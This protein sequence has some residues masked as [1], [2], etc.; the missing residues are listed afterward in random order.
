[1]IETLLGSFVEAVELRAG[2]DA[3]DP[4]LREE[5]AALGEVPAGRD[6]TYTA[7]RHCARRALARLG[8]APGPVLIGDDRAPVWPDGVVGSITHCQGYAAAAVARAAEVAA[9]GID[10][11]PHAPLPAGVL[12]RVAGAGD[13]LPV[14]TGQV[15]WDRVLFSAKESVFKAWWP[16]T[17]TWLGFGDARVALDPAS[18]RFRAVILISAPGGP[19]ALEGRFLVHDGLVLTAIAVAR[20]R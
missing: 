1:M 15:H 7:G 3:V 12:R 13:E 6:R 10:A 17:R 14:S 4:L 19:G 16:R 8:A 5:R 18:G 20:R 2:G 11:E 9:L